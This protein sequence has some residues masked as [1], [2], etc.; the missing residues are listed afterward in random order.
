MTSSRTR[1]AAPFIVLATTLGATAMAGARDKPAVLPDTIE[2]RVLACAACHARTDRDDAYFPRLAGKPAGYLYNQLTNFR[3]GRRQFPLMT[4]M[5]SQLPDAYLHEIAEHFASLPPLHLSAEPVNS[6]A[7]LLERGRQLVLKGDTTLRVPACV[8]C[9]G[10]RLTGVAPAIPGLAG[11]PRDYINAQ[12]GAWKNKVRRA[13]APD[14]MGEIAA[15]IPLQDVA[16]ISSWLASQPLPADAR[17][18]A[19][20]ARPLPLACGS[21]PD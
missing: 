19:S 17:P 13:H 21:S 6:S 9:H 10:A 3:A 11:L 4:Y 1:T 5:V 14:C 2:Q 15:R 20:I 7:T 8:A 16:A 12:F 18:A